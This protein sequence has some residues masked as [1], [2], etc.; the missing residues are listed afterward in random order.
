[1]LE[2]GLV[3]LNILPLS[4]ILGSFVDPAFLGSNIVVGQGTKN[5]TALDTYIALTC[6]A[7][8][9]T[10]NQQAQTRARVLSKVTHC[11]AVLG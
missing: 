9:V 10:V 5:F 11:H 8:L 2:K 7:L 1:M 3:P 4:E 6:F